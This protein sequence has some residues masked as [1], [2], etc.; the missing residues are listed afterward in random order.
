M[1]IFQ[2]E[3]DNFNSWHS[4]L[5][6]R[7]NTLKQDSKFHNIDIKSIGFLH[8]STIYLFTDREFHRYSSN[9]QQKLNSYILLNEYNHFG[10]SGIIYDNYIYHM[11]VNDKQQMI[12]SILDFQTIKHINNENLTDRFPF[13]KRFQHFCI[14]DKFIYFLVQLESDRYAILICLLENF[15][16]IH[17]KSTI[18][19][20]Y[21]SNPI[22]IC[23]IYIPYIEKTVLFIN[24]F[25]AKILHIII[26]EKYFKSISI[27]AHELFYYAEMNEIFFVLND[28][29]YTIN[30][31]EQKNFFLKCH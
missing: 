18:E 12:L 24:D 6:D 11:Y 9:F 20:L 26:N 14:Y 5:I 13:V 8:D 21:A 16:K 27:A 23:P 7:S 22:H 17:L 2:C 28:G 30:I 10:C 3:A 25:S 19:L 15:R 29:I 31:N 4:L 1:L